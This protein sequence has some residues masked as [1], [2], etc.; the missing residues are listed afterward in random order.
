MAIPTDL[1]LYEKIKKKVY[2]DIPKHSAYRSVILVQ[3]YFRKFI[4]LKKFR[5]KM[6][7]IYRIQRC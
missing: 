5:T 3:K 7:S 4:Y 1:F 2:K 6:L